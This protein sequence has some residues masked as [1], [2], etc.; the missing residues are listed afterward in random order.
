MHALIN[1]LA[2]A[3]ESF[4]NRDDTKVYL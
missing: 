2:N 3:I 1:V 4:E